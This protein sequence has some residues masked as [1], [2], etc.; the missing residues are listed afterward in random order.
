MT[1]FRACLG[2]KIVDL[3]SQV[4]PVQ[5]MPAFDSNNC[6]RVQTSSEVLEA[7]IADRK[8]IFLSQPDLSGF[9]NWSFESETGDNSWL[10]D[11]HLADDLAQLFLKDEICNDEQLA[12]ELASLEQYLLASQTVLVAAPKN[13]PS[14]ENAW[15]G[16][17]ALNELG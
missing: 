3:N 17:K 11:E 13:M 15:W 10:D 7:K 12:H 4:I 2:L 14:W 8:K 1:Y 5:V 9:S 16:E 6:Y